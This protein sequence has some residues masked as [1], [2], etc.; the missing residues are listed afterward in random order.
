MLY[1]VSNMFKRI[2]FEISRGFTLVE[3][4]VTISVIVILAAVVV[5][6]YDAYI[7]RIDQ[8]NIST[9]I[10]AYQKS[11]KAYALEKNSYPQVSTCLPKGAKC[12]TSAGDSLPDVFCATNAEVGGAH[13]WATDSTD[14]DITKYINGTTPAFPTVSSF[15]NCTSGFM[16]N[17]PCKPAGSI[18]YV[19]PAF[20]SNTGTSKYWSTDPTA[21]GFLVYY[22]DPK[23]TCGSKDVMTVSSS[24][25]LIFNSSA[26]YTRA[27]S[28]YREC[29]VGIRR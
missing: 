10:D 8:T 22:I 16:S 26:T 18:T 1:N 17:G 19:G 20:I 4:M 9:T 23:F 25:N 6:G 3:L 13:N 28:S 15:T 12:C 27:T 7:D 11:L 2:R 21:K 5:I 29:I 14:T 24:S